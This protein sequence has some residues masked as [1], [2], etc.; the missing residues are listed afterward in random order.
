SRTDANIAIIYKISV[1][2]IE[3]NR[4]YR[5]DILMKAILYVH[6]KGGSYLEAEQ[7]KKNCDGFDIFGVD[8][9]DYLP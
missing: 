1:C 5:G 4:S 6:G 8:Y 2:G 3:K 7:Y 9:N